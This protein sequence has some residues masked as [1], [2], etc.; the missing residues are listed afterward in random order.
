MKE[1]LI[2]NLKDFLHFSDEV[3]LAKQKNVPIVALES[4]IITHGMPFPDNYKTAI[5]AETMVREA[6]CVP[7]TIAVIKGE[8]KIGLSKNEIIELANNDLAQKLS[9]N[10]LSM[11]MAKK[12]NGSTTVAAT[13]C[14]AELAKISVF[15]TGGIGGAHRGSEIDFDI[16]ADIN[17]LSSS[18]INVVC[19]GPKAI[20]DI[21]KTVELL[22]SSGVPVITYKQKNIPAFWS[23]NSGLPSP[24]TTDEVQ[25]I[26]KSFLIRSKLGIKTGQLICNPIPV[27]QEIKSNVIEP[28]IKRSIEKA[29]RENIKGKDLTPFLLSEIFKITKG[30][31]LKANKAL[32]FNNVDLAS[33]IAN[34]L[35]L[36]SD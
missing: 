6:G 22:E 13:M 5:Q 12:F 15:A 34:T 2:Y 4:T 26:A 7:A 33:K 11:S 14:V 1:N 24:I 19:A 35:F 31:S 29:L 10:N 30:K 3:M 27:E 25:E 21:A 32:L 17:Q 36:M 16:S 28:I 8:I 9:V 20:L 23:R 18:P